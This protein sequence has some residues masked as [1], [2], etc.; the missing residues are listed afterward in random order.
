M[1]YHT[2]KLLGLTDKNFQFTENWLETRT[3]NHLTTHFIHARLDY[4]PKA[5]SKCG[6]KNEGQIIKNGTH[7]T[8]VQLLPLHSFPTFLS[9]RRTRFLCKECGAT[10]NAKTP[11]VEENC[12]ISRELKQKIAIDLA[13]NSSRKDIARQYFVSDVTVMRVMKECV[14]TFKPNW[15]FLP[16]VLCFDEFKA[17]KSCEGKMS[18]VFMDGQTRKL[19]GV[20]ESRRLA[21]LRTYFY[22]Y[23]RKARLKVKYIVTDM[24]APYFELA[25][26]LFPNAEIVTDRFHIIQQITRSLNQLRIQTMN[27]YQKTDSLKYS[28][29]KRFWK[30]FLKD[31]NSLDSSTY[32][33]NR[34]FKRPMTGKAIVDELL[35]YDHTL[36]I[37]YET[38][39]YLMYYFKQGK[40]RHF[41]DL[42]YSLDNRLPK[43][44]RKKL[45]FFKK[46][47]RGIKNA[48][49]TT[50]SNGPLEGTNNKIKVIKRVAYG[51]RNF[52]NLRDRI[53]LVQGLIFEDVKDNKKNLQLSK[54][55]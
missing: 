12:Y 52:A 14:K 25:K 13:Q 34:S 48:L 37:A 22:H 5:C 45:T 8:K 50:Y 39:Q 2:K 3:I 16:T 15:D 21:Y 53:Y 35:T 38:C 32:R 30:L 18:F 6:I 4:T 42:I 28:R 41:F 7:K 11:I 19:L 51:Y 20:L 49:S 40:S 43:W 54:A 44:F 23:S 26:D 29:L 46:Y 27:R 17:M 36:K 47:K 9:L 10:F 1:D 55:A 31:S 24:N 33:Y